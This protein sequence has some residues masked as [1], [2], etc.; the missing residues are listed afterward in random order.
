[1]ATTNEQIMREL[2]RQE[3]VQ[4]QIDSRLK[5][6]ESKVDKIDKTLS[7]LEGGRRMA[8]WLLGVFGACSG[9]VGGFL[10]WVWSKL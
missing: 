8:L 7:E 2:G 5:G 3:G 6:I 10:S 4:A 9:A 1:M